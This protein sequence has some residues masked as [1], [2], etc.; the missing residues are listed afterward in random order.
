MMAIRKEKLAGLRPIPPD[1]YC[2]YVRLVYMRTHVVRK[3]RK[4]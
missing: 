3:E 1:L 2:L 4:T